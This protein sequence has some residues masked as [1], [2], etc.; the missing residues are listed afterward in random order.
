MAQVFP[1]IIS[2]Y[3]VDRCYDETPTANN[4]YL[5]LQRVFIRA[6]QMNVRTSHM[7][8]MFMIYSLVTFLA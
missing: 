6:L 2:T 3:R 5:Q 1:R 4:K 7:L 8:A